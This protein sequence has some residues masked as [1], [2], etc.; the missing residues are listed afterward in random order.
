MRKDFARNFDEI[1]VKMSEINERNLGTVRTKL[2]PEP[3]RHSHAAGCLLLRFR[4]ETGLAAAVQ[5]AGAQPLCLC[6]APGGA[7]S[8]GQPLPGALG[9]RDRVRRWSILRCRIRPIG[10]TRPSVAAAPPTAPRPSKGRG[11]VITSAFLLPR[12]RSR[13]SSERRRSKPSAMSWISS[14][15]CVRGV[16]GA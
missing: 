10:P 5:E 9:G 7:T 3:R 12:R 8:C 2:L 13:S 1:W 4:R 16:S 14:R 15:T 6:G 11:P